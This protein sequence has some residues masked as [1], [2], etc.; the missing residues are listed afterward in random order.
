MRQPDNLPALCR[1]HRNGRPLMHVA[2]W[3]AVGSCA[4]Q[5]LARMGQVPL[6]PFSKQTPRV[7]TSEGR[8]GNAQSAGSP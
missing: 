4:A 3:R 2:T 8:A 7:P 5:T 6:S 1:V